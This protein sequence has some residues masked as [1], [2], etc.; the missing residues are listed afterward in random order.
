MVWAELWPCNKVLAAGL[1]FSEILVETAQLSDF[2]AN[3]HVPISPMQLASAATVWLAGQ[4]MVGLDTSRKVTLK[5]Q[6]SV[7]P[8]PSLAVNVTVWTVLWPLNGVLAA[9]L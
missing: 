6:V 8:L 3:A 5:E 9:G 4:V 7:L 2:E 1:W